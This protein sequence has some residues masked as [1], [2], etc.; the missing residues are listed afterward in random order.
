MAA[1]FTIGA[2]S[3]NAGVTLCCFCC[4]NTR[5]PTRCHHFTASQLI[6]T[7]KDDGQW[8]SKRVIG[9]YFKVKQHIHN[10][11]P[12]V[13]VQPLTSWHLLSCQW[14]DDQ[15]AVHHLRQLIRLHSANT[16]AT[17]HLFKCFYCRQ[18]YTPI[19]WLSSSLKTF[20]S[21]LGWS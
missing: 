20:T 3:S 14:P 16:G 12:N 15:E 4:I 17:K 18:R 5:N 2:G 9:P 7:W 21:V 10:P 13:S 6:S 11:L 8:K 19:H 1:I